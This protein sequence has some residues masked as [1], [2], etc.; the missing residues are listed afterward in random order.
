M[1]MA[2]GLVGLLV[3]IGVIAW[4]MHAIY[5]PDVQASL[6]AQ[7]KAETFVNQLNGV[8]ANGVRIEDT[9]AAFADMRGDGKLQD[10]QITQVRP[11]SPM[12]LKFGLR[13]N[14][15]V[16]AAIDGH[17]VR[18][19]LSGLANEQEG[20]DAIRDA[21]TSD[22]Q[23]VVQRGDVQITLPLPKPQQ[24][25]PPPAP[26]NTTAQNQ[27]MQQNAQR[28]EQQQEHGK[29]GNGDENG[30]MDELHQRLHALPT[31]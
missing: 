13:A 4:L 14:D 23:L 25:P 30:T 1:R 9:Y 29:S 24:P 16:I 27:Q 6:H 21:Y 19:D 28:T 5:L 8:D 10:L 15:V 22:G 2:F 18:T 17:T 7:Q 31:Y 11:G 12:E 3:T 20:K 26:S